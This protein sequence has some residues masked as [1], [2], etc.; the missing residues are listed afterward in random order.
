MVANHSISVMRSEN[1][2]PAGE[3][4]GRVSCFRDS[5]MNAGNTRQSEFERISALAGFDA[6]GA[7]LPPQP[8]M[9]I[10]RKAVCWW[11]VRTEAQERSTFLG[12]IDQAS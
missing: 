10:D 12:L 8:G 6:N 3:I 9:D 5:S 4:L 1:C 11:K 2:D 7:L